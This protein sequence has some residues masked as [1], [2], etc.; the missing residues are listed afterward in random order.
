MRKVNA[1]AVTHDVDAA[2]CKHFCV[3]LGQMRR[4]L[5]RVDNHTV[6]ALGRGASGGQRN[7]LGGA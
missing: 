3:S 7:F 6:A 5:M 2:I 4:E 1:I